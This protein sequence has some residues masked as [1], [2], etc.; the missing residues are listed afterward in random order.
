MKRSTSAFLL[1][2]AIVLGLGIEAIRDHRALA[3]GAPPAARALAPVGPPVAADPPL[4]PDQIELLRGALAAA[5]DQGFETGEFTPPQLDAL[6]RAHDALRRRQGQVLLLDAIAR[7]AL[8][9]HHGRLSGADF[10]NE[11]G[12]RPASFDPQASVYDAV[13][14]NRVKA[15][16]DDLPPPYVGYQQLM[17]GL[18]TYRQI[19][20]K[21][22]WPRIASGPDMRLGLDDDRVP[23]LKTRLAIEDPQAAKVFAQRASNPPVADPTDANSDSAASA[24][25]PGPDP[26]LYDADV[27]QAVRAFQARHGIDT[28]GVV[29][30]GTLAALNVTAQARVQQIKANMERWRWAPTTM[31]ADRVQVNIAAAV[32]TLFRDDQP[33]L[34]MRA[35]AGRLTDHTPM[36]QSVIRSIVFNPPWNVPASIAAKEIWPK[37]R[38]HPGYFAREDFRV[39]KTADGV[40]LQQRAGPKSAL[41]QVKFDFDNRFGVYLHDTPSH[42]AFSQQSR[43]ASHGCVRLDRPR[44]LAVMLLNDPAWTDA[45]ISNLIDSGET[46][47]IMLKQPTA[48]MIFYW[49]AFA[50]PDGVMNFRPDSYG[51]D[52][53]LLQ[54]IAAGAVGKA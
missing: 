35:I 33:V 6:L 10:D 3:A 28:T 51:W 18:K 44:A 9:V 31:P 25:P 49:T 23:A 53:E 40:R 21:G 15:W 26:L 47:R 17:A 13:T 14:S 45:S 19:A 48:V 12:M 38:A 27:D 29:G 41:G 5:P 4:R 46:R 36:L 43:L 30:K 34:S 32:M 22:G 16:L 1:A 54:R 2:L 42:L 20:A 11:W 7:Y 37:E 8:A 39:I 52:N 24:T 50:G